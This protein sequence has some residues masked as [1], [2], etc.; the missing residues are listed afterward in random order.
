MYAPSEKQMKV[1]RNICLFLYKIITEEEKEQAVLN[2]A[3]MWQFTN[4]YMEQY[5]AE[6]SRVYEENKARRRESIGNKQIETNV[7]IKVNGGLW[8]PKYLWIVCGG[9]Y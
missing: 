3:T 9:G 2:S 8:N 1:Y 7:K 6:R 5:L 4:K